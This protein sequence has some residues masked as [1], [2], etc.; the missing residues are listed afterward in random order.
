MRGVGTCDIIRAEDAR[1]AETPPHAIR[2]AIR[3]WLGRKTAGAWLDLLYWGARRHPHFMRRARPLF[4]WGAWKYSPRLR[5]D[6]MANARRLL[7]G[8]STIA[9]RESLARQVIGNCYD[10]VFDVGHSTA[11]GRRRLLKQI[12]RIEGHETYMKARQRGK[13]AIL[14]TAHMG[15]FEV[16]IAALLEHE[17]R[18]HV[19]FRRD[20]RS[21]FEKTRS[22][23][24]RRLGVV[25][26]CV[27][28]GL[29][30][31]VRLREALA[32]DEVVLIQGDRVMPGQRGQR[33]PFLGGHVLLPIGPIKLAHASGAPIIPVFSIRRPDGKIDLFIE[34]PIPVKEEDTAEALKLVS[35]VIE[36]YVRRYPEQWLIL[37]RAWCE[38]AQTPG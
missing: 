28:D 38:D 13:G 26:A 15:S 12:E 33:M 8:Q 6:A 11:M 18:V 1:R 20:T 31:W 14:V 5:A 29:A 7:G 21:S 37:D 10:F 17:R 2:R 34:N 35:A 32:D 24:R 9:Q 4:L 22:A 36:K 19:L 3:G 23:L 30:V 16:A 25:E 27:D